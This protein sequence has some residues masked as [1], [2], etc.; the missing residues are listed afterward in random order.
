MNRR[1]IMKK[2]E[3]IKW[4]VIVVI[5]CIAG[6]I[7]VKYDYQTTDKKDTKDVLIESTTD[8]ETQT[9]SGRICVQICGHVVNPGVYEVSSGTRVYEVVKLAGGFTEDADD[10]ALNQASGVS[11]GQQIYVS[12]KAEQTSIAANGPTESQGSLININQADES[13]L[14]ELPGIG[15]SK[16]TAII[17]YRES[18]GTFTK[19]EDIMKVAGIKEAAFSKIKELICV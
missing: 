13:M 1:E 6:Y 12:S 10:K 11:D 5:V 9:T 15:K 14:M 17:S 3:V 4:A 8:N 7:Y 19:V 18:K 2:T 16:A